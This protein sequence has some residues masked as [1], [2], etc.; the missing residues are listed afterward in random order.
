MSIY[1]NVTEQDLINLRKLAEQQKNQRAIKIKNR[2][3]EKT[4]DKKL[5]ESL[6]PLTKRLDL[7]ENNKGEKIGD[8]IKKLESESETLAIENTPTQPETPAIENTPTQ[9]ETPGIENTAIPQP[10]ENNEGVIYDVELENTLYNMKDNVGFFKIEER[11][12]GDVFWNGFPVE[13]I[14]GNKI[15]IIENIFNITRGIQNVLTDKSK[16]SIKKL[17]DQDREI[18]NNILESLDFKNYKPV[19]GESKSGRYKQ[20]KTNFKKHNLKG[21]GI[22]K[23]LI[24]SNIIDIYTRLEILLGLKLSG[25]TDTLTEASNLIDEL[26]K[27]GEIQNEQQYRNAINKF[28][29]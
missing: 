10:I 24:P 13:K 3:L 5:A 11:D 20:S 25:H 6:S 26:Y 4:H 14:G 8:I 9:P 17:N 22:E 29:I 16:T 15:K 12:N 18:F 7:I 2:I 23:I 27:R 28:K 1:S 21:Q 19:R